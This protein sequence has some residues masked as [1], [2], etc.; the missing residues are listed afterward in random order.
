MHNVNNNMSL[1]C[2]HR[3]DTQNSALNNLT[4]YFRLSRLSE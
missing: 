1:F 2:Y 4:Y 3:E